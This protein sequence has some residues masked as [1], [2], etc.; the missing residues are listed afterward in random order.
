MKTLLEHDKRRTNDPITGRKA[1]ENMMDVCQFIK[2]H[3]KEFA[4]ARLEKVLGSMKKMNLRPYWAYC[5]EHLLDIG[6]EF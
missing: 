3:R 6:F 4:P 2:D 5:R 1:D